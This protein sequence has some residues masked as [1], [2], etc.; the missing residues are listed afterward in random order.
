MVHTWEKASMGERVTT[1]CEGL[2]LEEGLNVRG[3]SREK[4]LI[5]WELISSVNNQAHK[6]VLESVY[7][8]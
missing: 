2:K 6:E 5:E 8:E 4:G 7:Y 1:K 3:S